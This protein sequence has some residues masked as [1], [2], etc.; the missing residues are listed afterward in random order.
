M[1]NAGIFFA[2]AILV[3]FSL[4][5]Q[6][7]YADTLSFDFTDPQGDVTN[8]PDILTVSVEFD[9][10]TGDYTVIV[11]ADPAN[12]FVGNFVFN[13]N[14]WN[15]DVDPVLIAPP[16]P[17]GFASAILSKTFN[18]H[19]S[20]TILIYSDTNSRLTSWGAGDQ[21]LSWHDQND[22]PGTGTQLFSSGSVNFDFSS[23]RDEMRDGPTT[24]SLVTGNGDSQVIGGEIIPI[25]QTSLLLAGAQTF[26]WMIPV[27]L[28][29]LGIGLFVVS[30]K[31]E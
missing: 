18:N 19:P 22:H 7:A 3:S 1:K 11:T 10:I 31:S 15:P 24:I 2:A 30:R 6:Q 23:F 4:S 8:A 13:L 9:N 26:S 27:V 28:S 5:F 17:E 12:P 21:V 25:E 14:L 16:P 29:A 20:D